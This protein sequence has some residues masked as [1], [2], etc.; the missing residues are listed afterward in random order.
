MSS[1][2]KGWLP[3]SPFNTTSTFIP[4]AKQCL[5]Q[6]LQKPAK[7]TITSPMERQLPEK[8]VLADLKAAIQARLDL[9]DDNQASPSLEHCAIIL[10]ALQNPQSNT[11]V[12]IG[13][14][15]AE[16]AVVLA[17]T[18]EERDFEVRAKY[19]L[20]SADTQELQIMPPL[21]IHEQPAA[22][23]SKAINKYTDNLPYDKLLID[24]TMHLNYRIQNKDMT[25]IPDLYLAVT[26]QPPE[27]D[28][29]D[30]IKILKPI[31]K[32]VG[33]CGLSSDYNFMVW[34]L[35][36]TCNG[37]RDIDLALI[38]EFKERATW[39][40]PKEMSITA[41][42]LC[43]SPT[44]DYKEFIP[45]RIKKSLKF[46]PVIIHSHVWIDISEVQY[47]VFRHGVDGHFDFNSKNPDTFAEGMSDIEHILR[48]G[49]NTL[50]GYII[51]LMEGM[52]LEASEIQLVHES[53]PVVGLGVLVAS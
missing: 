9:T 5:Q 37:H 14:I 29:V 41:Q 28:S 8:Q 52:N 21:P 18:S 22:H 40:Q 19:A 12:I 20:S 49:T 11:I 35:S 6:Q 10:E 32:W 39:Q 44:L 17:F 2:S 48:D 15:P 45:T 30:D 34:K 16:Y 31:S 36:G 43:M 46:G 1:G 51:S 47:T 50:K 33:E 23:L 13:I 38:M 27:D 42:T 24:V 53:N 4:P 3:T 26:I 7:P 25:N